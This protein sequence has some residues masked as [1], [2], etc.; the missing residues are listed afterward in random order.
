VPVLLGVSLVVLLAAG[1]ASYLPASRAAE[2]DP[3]M[4]LRHE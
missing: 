4:A 1:A 3:G 2:V